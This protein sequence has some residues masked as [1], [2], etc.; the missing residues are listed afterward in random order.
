MYEGVPKFCV[1]D[2]LVQAGFKADLLKGFRVV[3]GSKRHPDSVLDYPLRRRFISAVYY[4]LVKILIG[5]P[6]KDTQTGLKLFKRKTLEWAMPRLLVKRFAFD[7]EL[8]AIIHEKGFS[9]SE[10]P[11]TLEFK[12]KLGC[13]RPIT[14]KQVMQDTLAIFYRLRLLHYYQKLPDAGPEIRDT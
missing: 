13:V 8:L 11:I 1:A 7:L 9:V 12:G 6:V 10:S 14:V 4:G 3:I 5:L 2:R